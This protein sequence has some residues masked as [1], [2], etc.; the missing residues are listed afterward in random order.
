MMQSLVSVL[1]QAYRWLCQQRRDYPPDADVWDMRFH[2]PAERVRLEADLRAGRY[3]FRPLS[4]LGP[5][6]CLMVGAMH[7]GGVLADTF[8]LRR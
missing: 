6:C 3:R 4:N 7:A 5:L 1:D 8:R 2:R